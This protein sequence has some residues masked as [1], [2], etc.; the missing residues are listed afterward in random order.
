MGINVAARDRR[1]TGSARAAG[2]APPGPGSAKL[3]PEKITPVQGFKSDT[4]SYCGRM[5]A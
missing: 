4:H 1:S 3:R 5:G 2:V